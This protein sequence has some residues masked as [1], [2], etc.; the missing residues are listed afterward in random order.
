M[1]TR[2]LT[3]ILALF[4][5][6]T[7][8]QAQGNSSIPAYRALLEYGDF[9]FMLPNNEKNLTLRLL[10][11]NTTER[12]AS[13]AWRNDNPTVAKITE[14]TINGT[15][16]NFKVESYSEG[17][18]IFTGTIT[19]DAGNTFKVAQEVDVCQKMRNID[20]A[21]VNVNG[22]DGLYCCVGNSGKGEFRV[23][24]Q[25]P[26][27]P[28]FLM[29]K[30]NYVCRLNGNPA[31]FPAKDF[32]FVEN[33]FFIVYVRE[34]LGG[35][36]DMQFYKNIQGLPYKEL[37]FPTPTGVIFTPDHVKLK[38]QQIIKIRA[39]A[40]PIG[41]YDTWHWFPMEKIAEDG[42]MSKF[43]AL[44]V[45]LTV[46][47][48]TFTFKGATSNVEGS[49]TAIIGDYEE[50]TF[51]VTLRDDNSDGNNHLR[52]KAANINDEAYGVLLQG[53]TLYRDGRWNTLCLPFD[54]DNFTGTPLDGATVKKLASSSY[55]D[56]TKT[57]T[58]NF[59]TVSSIEYGR[60]Y[61]VR[62]NSG[63]NVVNPMFRDVKV[64]RPVTPADETDCVDFIG[65]Y[66]PVTLAAQDRTVLYLGGDSKLYY[67]GVDVPVNAFRGYFQLKNGLTA[68]DLPTN[69]AKNIVLNF[70]DSTTE[71]GASLNDNGQWINDNFYSIDG[72]K[73]QGEPTQ[74]GIYIQNG[75]KIVK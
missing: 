34:D 19:T 16:A 9:V 8:V 6:V 29:R 61:L 47:D 35:A 36:V 20:M 58:L 66:S 3:T 73:L 41:A 7:A 67:P 60:P 56:D 72:R 50:N 32:P 28:D 62:W 42:Y 46:Y 39:T 52:I 30:E 14:T 11:Y 25:E 55:S 68:G 17:Y 2:I 65:C 44:S 4:A 53:R 71:I 43:G 24:K 70:G 13:I 15:T 12:I 51:G 27:D 10:G 49:I 33:D 38:D 74:K 54:L 5:M 26:N 48:E 57:L 64:H 69:G 37:D 40:T 1:K 45:P 59:E 63:G 21:R 75:K 23:F 18:V 22:K 31:I